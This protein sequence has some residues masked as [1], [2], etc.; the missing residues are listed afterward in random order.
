LGDAVIATPVI[1]AGLVDLDATWLV[2][3]GLFLVLYAILAIAF[4]RPYVAFLRR[5]DEATGGLRARAGDLLRRARDLEESIDRSL[6]EARA[7][8]VRIR[9][10]LSEE[11]ERLRDE[12]AARE[13]ARMQ[14]ELD[15]GIEAI[16]ARKREFMLQMDAVAADVAALIESQAA[17][18]EG[19]R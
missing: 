11:G 7:E 1:Q 4:F 19:R 8:A 2:Q 17:A 12:I 6:A 16:E 14:A 18:P 13:R 5:R 9:R 3:I 15:R 10:R